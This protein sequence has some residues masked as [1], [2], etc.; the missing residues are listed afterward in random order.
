MWK[1]AKTAM[2]QDS[3]N[4]SMR[5]MS[6]LAAV[7]RRK[8][9][10]IKKFEIMVLDYLNTEDFTLTQIHTAIDKAKELYCSLCGSI[11]CNVLYDEIHNAYELLDRRKFIASDQERKCYETFCEHGILKNL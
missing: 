1:K 4:H 7:F 11:Y 6:A 3:F 10:I 8:N 2:V 5:G 9:Y